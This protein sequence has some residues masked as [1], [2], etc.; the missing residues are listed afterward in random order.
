VA[1]GEKGNTIGEW[2]IDK[3]KFLDKYLPTFAKATQR[4]KHRYYIDGFA[5][6]GE[7]IHRDTGEYVEGSAAIALKN[8]E[9]FTKLHFVEMDKNRSD[10]LANL[11]GSFSAGNKTV[12]H[13]GDTNTLLPS[14]MK[15]IHPLAPTFVFLDPSGDQ[16]NWKTI[17][18]LSKWQTELFILY[19]YHMTIARYL[20]IDGEIEDWQIERLNKFFGTH[21]WYEIYLNKPRNYL[22]FELLNLYTSRLVN[23]GYK[24][25]NVSKCF[26]STTGQNLYYMIW[27]GK[28]PAGKKIM[29]WVF[30][31][32]EDQLS[33]DI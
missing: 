17:E 16:L 15:K 25:C 26:K 3:L 30:K 19:P 32:Q 24:Y 29:D 6:N 14:I 20:P 4:A 31:Q 23:I 7:W 2:S 27:V 1:Y 12:I 5:G 11:V 22:L 33:F 18:S 13:Q 8:A 9:G 21:D 28:H 10:N